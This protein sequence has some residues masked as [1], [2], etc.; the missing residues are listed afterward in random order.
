MLNNGDVFAGFTIERLLGQG[1]MGSVYL[2]RHPR[3]G[4]LTALKL[5]NRELFA[6][7]EIRAR[8]ERE[9][10]LVA[11]LDHPNI[12]EVY[13]RGSED[14]QLWIS[15]Q[16]IDG[17]DAAGVN[18]TQLPPERAVQIIEGVA[19][20]LDYAHTRGVLHRDVKPANIIL[21]RAVAGHG[22]RVFLTDFGI[23]RLREDSTHLTQRGMFTATLAYASPEQMT[24][25][26]LD[27]TTDQ[28]SLACALYWLLIGAGPYDSPHPAELIRGHLQLLPPPVSL[29]RPGLT[30][31]MDA[32]LTKAMAKRPVDRFPSCADFAKAARR[33]L[34]SG[35]VPYPAAAPYTVAPPT[36]GAPPA[37]AYPAAP[38]AYPPQAPNYPPGQPA[39]APGYA[40]AQQ[41]PGGASVPA[42]GY[43][44]AQPGAAAPMPSPGFPAAPQGYPAAPPNYPAPQQHPAA[45]QPGQMPPGPAASGY[46]GAPQSPNA[47]QP[48][49]APPAG[50]PA[51]AN[52]E[53]PLDDSAYR[54]TDS[55]PTRRVPSGTSEGNPADPTSTDSGTP[56][57]EQSPPPPAPPAISE[58]PSGDAPRQLTALP[59]EPDADENASRQTDSFPTHRAPAEDMAADSTAG[60]EDSAP[61]GTGP[62]AA[63][64]VEAPSKRRKRKASRKSEAMNPAVAPENEAPDNDAPPPATA[65]Q[66][67][68][69]VAASDPIAQDDSAARADTESA[70]IAGA[71]DSAPSE[72]GDA[73]EPRAEAGYPGAGLRNPE[74]GAFVPSAEPG[75]ASP[76]K[77]GA[78]SV[79][80]REGSKP[81][82]ADDEPSPTAQAAETPSAAA[83][84]PIEPQPG[85]AQTAAAPPVGAIPVG[86]HPGGPPPGQ[87]GPAGYPVNSP[88]SQQIPAGVGRSQVTA[89]VVLGLAV[90]AL[91][92][93]LAL[94][95]VQVAG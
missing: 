18:V 58:E 77:R 8:F 52:P 95:V 5:L 4:R 88:P 59:H 46:V 65:E 26:H 21:A 80:S 10:D 68:P 91:L 60:E 20:A 71:S 43:S 51:P 92:L 61:S 2:A 25:A 85:A 57:D 30:Q 86:P 94:V 66:T 79:W 62:A 12:V 32:V 69:P 87:F 81:R 7:R 47:P 40:P 73:A 74:S 11:Q 45:Q 36:Y 49:P 9:A 38:P 19:E 17:V 41:A 56:G 33:A 55:F 75:A 34:T 89:L 78:D 13:D 1:G 76:A 83:Q 90:L 3:L 16:Y 24:G 93:M 70:R 50:S 39:P 35:P 44:P 23:A 72:D 67:P 54:P 22:E 31:A 48:I 27:H 53:A 29:R 63:S 14:E 64:A 6:D 15:M 42:P 82:E 84:P 37:A 28:Y